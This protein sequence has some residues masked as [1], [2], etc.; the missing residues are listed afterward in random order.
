LNFYPSIAGAYHGLFF[1]PGNISE[2]NAGSISLTLNG[3]GVVNGNLTF[4]HGGY[5]FHFQMGA[6]GVGTVPK[7][8]SLGP[9]D[10]TMIFDVTDL[11]G[12]MTGFVRQGSEVTPLTAY[13]AASKLSTS[14]APSPGKYVLSLK[15]ETPTNGI[16]DGPLGKSYASVIVSAGGNLAVAG[17]LADNTPFSLST[18]VFTNGVWPL[19]ASFDKGHGMLIGWETNSTGVCTGALFW[20]K[21]PTNGIYYPGG[22]QEDLNSVGAKYVPPTAGTQYQIVFGGGTLGQA[23]VT[24][25]FSFNAA[26]RIVPAAGTTDKLTGSLLSTGVLSKGSIL[27]PIT[28]QILKFSGALVGPS[29]GGGFPVQGG[30]FTLDTGTQTGYFEINLVTP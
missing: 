11:S 18:G 29:Q 22:V 24:N 2:T 8:G 5:P 21:S 25:V 6:T 26:G 7:N 27:N 13:R 9:L 20:I 1:D 23:W 15:P 3:T 30:G 17:T 10:L 4:P 28:S 12:Q 19:Y 16:L 14:T